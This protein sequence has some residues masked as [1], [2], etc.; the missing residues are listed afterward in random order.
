[1]RQPYWLYNVRLKDKG[2]LTGYFSLYI[3]SDPNCCPS[4]GFY[5]VAQ[6]QAGFMNVSIYSWND[7]NNNRIRDYGECPY[8]GGFKKK[9]TI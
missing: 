6:V 9:Q 7:E 2:I 8:F 1:M 4:Y 3:D 5:F